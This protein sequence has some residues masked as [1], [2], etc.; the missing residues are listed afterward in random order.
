MKERKP[1]P[2]GSVGDEA[3][4]D[5]ERV[6]RAM[7]SSRRVMDMSFLVPMSPKPPERVT[8]A[9]RRPPALSAMGALIMRGLEVHG[10]V[11]WRDGMLD[12]MANEDDGGVASDVA[13]MDCRCR[14]M[15]ALM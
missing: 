12:I 10:K 8:V 11:S 5:E 13:M 1:I 14:E 6:E 3:C 4:A 2:I 9:A 7:A 15:S